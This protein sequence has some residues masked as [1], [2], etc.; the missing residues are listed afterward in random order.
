MSDK[1]EGR[2]T[3]ETLDILKILHLLPHR[4]PFL[5]VDRII[6]IKRGQSCTGIK[7][8]TF[9]E[10]HFQGHFPM[11]PIVPGVMI[12]E[13]MAQA[14]GCVALL[15]A[16]DDSVAQKVYLMTVDKAKFRKPV[17]PGDVMEYHMSLISRRRNM[18]WFRG[19]AIVS[20]KTVAEAELGAM[21]VAD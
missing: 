19:E 10:P 12:I 3:L 21:I 7:N 8:V 14:G 15:D 17:G 11:M 9:N 4:Y 6:D 5:L 1:I 2:T 16:D 20:G 13:G 18:W